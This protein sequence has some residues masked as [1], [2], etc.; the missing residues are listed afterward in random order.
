MLAVFSAVLV[1]LGS[2]QC[3]ESSTTKTVICS[4]IVSV[5]EDSGP[6][7]V[8]LEFGGV[9]PIGCQNHNSDK[10][11]RD[12]LHVGQKETHISDNMS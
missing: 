10:L 6:D 11:L 8:K 7:Q 4:R 9:D 12:G 2:M 5:R 1:V 3:C